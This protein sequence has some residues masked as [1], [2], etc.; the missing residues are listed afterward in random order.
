M[1]FPWMFDDFA[2]LAPLKGAAE[3]LAAKEDWPRLYD[4]AALQ[5]GT[6]PVASA[7]YFED[8][9]V[10]MGCAQVRARPARLHAA[11]LSAAPAQGDVQLEAALHGVCLTLPCV[12][13]PLTVLASCS[14][15]GRRHRYMECPLFVARILL[16]RTGSGR[17]MQ[18]GDAC[19]QEA[20]AHIRGG[21]S[22]MGCIHCRRR[23]RTSG[24]ASL[25][26]AACIAGGSSAHQGRHL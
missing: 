7:T 12:A 9:Y 2:A 25:T 23:Q 14:W 10:D 24:A 18:H 22:D 1:V 16:S 6:V 15:E 20:A 13:V 4:A 21:I 19:M 5:E 8:M 26:W 11:A 3:A 17:C